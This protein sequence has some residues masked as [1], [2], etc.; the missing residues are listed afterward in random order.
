LELLELNID[1][2]LKQV[3]QNLPK[4]NCG[5]IFDDLFCDQQ[6]FGSLFSIQRMLISKLTRVFLSL[7]TLIG[8]HISLIEREEHILIDSSLLPALWLFFRFFTLAWIVE[9]TGLH[10]RFDISLV[11]LEL[12]RHEIFI[13]LLESLE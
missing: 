12:C 3:A 2:F 7:S 8:L 13:Y 6:L 5:L 9:D 11:H 4:A 1:G 10:R